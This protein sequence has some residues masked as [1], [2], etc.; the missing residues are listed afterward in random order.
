LAAD[1]KRGFQKLLGLSP[2][3]HLLADKILKDGFGGDFVA[4][5]LD[6]GAQLSNDSVRHKLPFGKQIDEV[7]GRHSFVR[8]WIPP[9]KTW[10]GAHAQL[11]QKYFWSIT[12][13]V[14]PS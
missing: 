2:G 10:R 6:L 5:L 11:A 14:N 12:L 1:A 8:R 9:Q 13:K 3:N 4:G 7:F